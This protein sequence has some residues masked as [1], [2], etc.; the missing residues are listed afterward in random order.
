MGLEIKMPQ[1][2]AKSGNFIVDTSHC[3][4]SCVGSLSWN[5]ALSLRVI[6]MET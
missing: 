6:S 4:K 2:G 5:N 1:V 3:V